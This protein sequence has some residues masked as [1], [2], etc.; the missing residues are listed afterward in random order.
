MRVSRRHRD[1]GCSVPSAPHFFHFLPLKFPKLLVSPNPQPG[2]YSSA[3][4]PLP[5]SQAAVASLW[6]SEAASLSNTCHYPRE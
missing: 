5:E 1:V 4:I 6:G 2:T 3:P